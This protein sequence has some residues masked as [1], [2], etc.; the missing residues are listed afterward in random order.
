[1]STY[2]EVCEGDTC[3]GEQRFLWLH[4]APGQRPRVHTCNLITPTIRVSVETSDS[5]TGTF[6][7]Q[8]G[9]KLVNSGFQKLKSE[10]FDASFVL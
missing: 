9:L 7:R 2:W 5:Q 10:S 3:R 1:M 4:T 6:S 8:V